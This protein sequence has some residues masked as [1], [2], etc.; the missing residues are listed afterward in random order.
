MSSEGTKESVSAV[1]RMRVYRQRRR[2]GLRAIRVLMH[3]TQNEVL[4]TKGFL[5]QERRRNQNAV[6]S[7][8]DGFLCCA[9]CEAAS[10]VPRPAEE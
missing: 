7:A 2:N 9:F 1:E 10:D 3:E 4:I 6:D 8:V 5:K